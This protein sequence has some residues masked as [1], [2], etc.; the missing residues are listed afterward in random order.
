[1][2]G[3]QV[4]EILREKLNITADYKL[5]EKLELDKSEIS[6]VRKGQS[7]KN[8]LK[9]VE[10]IYGIELLKEVEAELSN[11]VSNDFVGFDQRLLS[12]K[13]RVI[14]IQQQYINN[15][16]RQLKDLREE[17]KQKSELMRSVF[18]AENN[19]DKLGIKSGVPFY[20]S[21]D[22]LSENHPELKEKTNPE[23][24]KRTK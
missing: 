21:H 22:P 19:W 18:G 24:G 10:E 5:G 14:N 2:E 7:A 13:D 4:I 20:P 12:E 3:I 17:I 1:M 15:L 23:M 11:K 6:R 9:K 16:E 8:I